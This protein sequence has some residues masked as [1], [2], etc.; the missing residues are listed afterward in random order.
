MPKAQ[1]VEIY[2]QDEAPKIGCGRRLVKMEL[3]HK[4]A[5][6]TVPTTGVKQKVPVD[7]IKRLAT[8]KAKVRRQYSKPRRKS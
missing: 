5:Y 4:W 3:G 8:I 6:L 7:V 2:L 1:Y